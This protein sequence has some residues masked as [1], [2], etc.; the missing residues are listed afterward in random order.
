M[1]QLLIT[2][3]S[4]ALTAGLAFATVN[5]TNIGALSGG[6][7]AEQ[8]KRGFEA[9]A[10]AS[11]TMARLGFDAPTTLA[12]FEDRVRMSRPLLPRGGEWILE[13][14]GDFEGLEVTRLCA[15]FPEPSERLLIRAEKAF[16]AAAV[17]RGATCSDE[18]TATEDEALGVVIWVGNRPVRI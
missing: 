14:N 15:V 2:V 5:Y 16:P 8:V 18:T 10:E 6:K 13:A 17:Q 12:Q 4:I 1:F 9:F 3:L 7:E 11:D